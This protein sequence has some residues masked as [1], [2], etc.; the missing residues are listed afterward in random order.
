VNN[1]YGA[2]TVDDIESETSWRWS[3]LFLNHFE[4]YS[5]V[6]V[7]TAATG[8]L[9]AAVHFRYR[10]KMRLKSPSLLP[11]RVDNGQLVTGNMTPVTHE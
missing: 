8:L 5:T 9:I 4:L 11:G 1:V 6:A 2:M 3:Y 10:T 7:F